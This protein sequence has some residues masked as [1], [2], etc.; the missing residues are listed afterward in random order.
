MSFIALTQA[1][2]SRVMVNT[3]KIVTCA[4]VPRDARLEQGTRI[5]FTNGGQQDVIELVTEVA[6]LINESG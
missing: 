4:P 5:T 6:R 2:G 3:K 1:D